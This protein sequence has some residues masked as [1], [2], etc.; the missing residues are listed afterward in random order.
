MVLR[1]DELANFGSIAPHDIDAAVRVDVGNEFIVGREGPVLGINPSACQLAERASRNLKVPYAQSA[2]IVRGNDKRG[3]VR[4]N[5]GDVGFRQWHRYLCDLSPGY[6]DLCNGLQVDILIEIDS[7]AIG[8][9]KI[10]PVAVVGDP[11]IFS[12]LQR[13]QWATQIPS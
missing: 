8:S 7:A 11:G 3:P 10:L 9:G 13:R 6:R 1:C 12:D 4:R 5:I 2:A